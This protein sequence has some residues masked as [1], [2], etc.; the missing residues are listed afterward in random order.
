MCIKYFWYN[1]EF[2]KSGII[3]VRK[4]NINDGNICVSDQQWIDLKN[5]HLLKVEP[6][7]VI[8]NIIILPNILCSLNQHYRKINRIITWINV[9]LI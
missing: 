9:Y 7:N 8:L 2:D 6:L 1:L 4:L 3:D 5:K